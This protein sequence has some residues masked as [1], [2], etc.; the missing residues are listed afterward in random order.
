MGARLS[1]FLEKM[2]PDINSKDFTNEESFCEESSC[3]SLY[4]EG[5]ACSKLIS[6]SLY[7]AYK[8]SDCDKTDLE[9]Y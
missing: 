4:C 8:G 3:K 9:D 1:I 6:R 2:R 5:L 7:L